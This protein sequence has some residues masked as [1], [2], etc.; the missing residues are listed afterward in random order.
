MPKEPPSRPWIEIHDGYLEARLLGK[1]SM[2]RFKMRAVLLVALCHAHHEKR[3]L[4][5]L[6]GIEGTLS[7]YDRF[8]MGVQAALLGGD[9]TIACIASLNLL[10]PERLGMKVARNGGLKIEVFSDRRA[11]VAWLLAEEPS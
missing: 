6:T 3:L 7:T 9:L 1:F 2:S 4:L 5:D 8:E 10:D 11:A